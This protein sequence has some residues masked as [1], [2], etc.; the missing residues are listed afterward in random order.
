M[1]RP[2][3]KLNTNLASALYEPFTHLACRWVW[4]SCTKAIV[5][6]NEEEGLTITGSVI[7]P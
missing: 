6:E 5:E 7:Y 1:D 2:W 4:E 3:P